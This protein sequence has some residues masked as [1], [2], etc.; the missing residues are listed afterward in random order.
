EAHEG[1]RAERDFG[2]VHRVRGAVV[3]DALDA[4]DRE[5]D[6]RTLLDRLAEA[7]L[8]GRDEL[9]RDG[10][11]DDVV[12]ELEAGRVLGRQRLDVAAHLAVLARATGLLLVGV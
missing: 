1:G 7:L 9:A 5:P 3:D 10:A 8:A 6:Q 12:L 11:A 2:R 4:V